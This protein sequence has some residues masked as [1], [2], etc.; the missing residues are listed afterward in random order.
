MTSLPIRITKQFNAGRK[1]GRMHQDV[2]VFL[3]GDHKL[4]S[5]ACGDPEA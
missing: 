2:L 1:A 5:A 4:A 3:K